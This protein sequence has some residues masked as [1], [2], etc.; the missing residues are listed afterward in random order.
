MTR[1]SITLSG[2]LAFI[3]PAGAALAAPI[4]LAPV[5]YETA[6]AE[7]I[8]HVFDEI[9][10][11]HSVFVRRDDFQYD[12][13]SF[14]F[15]I[16]ALSGMVVSDAILTLVTVS[17]YVDDAF[18]LYGYAG[19]GVTSFDDFTGGTLVG[20]LPRGWQSLGPNAVFEVGSFLQGLA[21]SSA[22]HAG[23]YIRLTYEELGTL[24]PE[25]FRSGSF[26]FM[27]FVFPADGG[28]TLDAEIPEPA[29]AVLLLQGIGTLAWTRRRAS[30]RSRRAPGPRCAGA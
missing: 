22:T 27:Q 21:A 1:R 29:T 12:R 16:G 6:R 7:E 23:F 3:L 4:A 5:T 8:D 20:S 14:E 24:P 19:D 28:L 25:P 30:Q 15:D 18:E 10:S 13:A 9:F 2:L 17:G 11:V 26:Q